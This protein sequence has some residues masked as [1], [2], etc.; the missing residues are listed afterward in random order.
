MN[1]PCSFGPAKVAGLV[2]PRSVS[3][4]AQLPGSEAARD[5][6]GPVAIELLTMRAFKFFDE[7]TIAGS[8]T[9]RGVAM[10]NIEEC[11]HIFDNVPHAGNRA[12]ADGNSTVAGVLVATLTPADL[13]DL[14]LQLREVC[15]YHVKEELDIFEIT[16][17]GSRTTHQ[18]RRDQR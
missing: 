4:Q 1:E 14:F 11:P 17:S 7:S 8:D 18:V 16:T 12:H 13:L 6:L 15:F 5:A 2:L 3:V 9:F 10:P